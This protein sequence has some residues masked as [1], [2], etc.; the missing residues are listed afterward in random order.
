VIV[1]AKDPTP[2]FPAFVSERVARKQFGI[3]DNALHAARQAGSLPW[4]E[5]SGSGSPKRFYTRELY[6]LTAKTWTQTEFD[7]M[8]EL[9]APK[10]LQRLTGLSKKEIRA[11][12]EAGLL[13]QPWCSNSGYHFYWKKDLALFARYEYTPLV[14]DRV[15]YLVKEVARLLGVNRTMINEMVCRKQLETVN[16]AEVISGSAPPRPGPDATFVRACELAVFGSFPW[17]PDTFNALPEKMLLKE[18]LVAV[19][20]SPRSARVLKAT[21]FLTTPKDVRTFS[22]DE[23]RGLFNVPVSKIGLERS[24]AHMSLLEEEFLKKLCRFVRTRDRADLQEVTL[25]LMQFINFWQISI[26]YAQ[27]FHGSHWIP[28][29]YAADLALPS[30]DPRKKAF[31]AMVV[32]GGYER[33]ASRGLISLEELRL[34]GATSS[35]SLS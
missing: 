12:R 15:A 20:I 5:M 17:K 7:R 19:P 33:L 2:T 18:L 8:G 11:A 13:G 10:H 16:I 6:R 22:K 30:A 31:A 35:V 4:L 9:I 29:D 1:S 21:Q 34:V 24:V 26:E 23:L 14:L 3:T 25:A 32:T 28:P 27:E